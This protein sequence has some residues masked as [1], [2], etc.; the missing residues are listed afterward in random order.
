MGSKCCEKS[1]DK[2][3]AFRVIVAFAIGLLLCV[4]QLA[5]GYFIGLKFYPEHPWILGTIT[6]SIIMLVVGYALNMNERYNR[7]A[8][9]AVDWIF[10]V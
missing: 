4:V 10:H 3:L 1:H 7:W 9:K 6:Y 5:I 2:K 8:M